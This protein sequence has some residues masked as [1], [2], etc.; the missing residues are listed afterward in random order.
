VTL[1]NGKDGTGKSCVAAWLRQRAAERGVSVVSARLQNASG[2]RAPQSLWRKIFFQLTANADAHSHDDQWSYANA[3]IHQAFPNMALLTEHVSLTTLSEALGV[4]IMGSGRSASDGQPRR[5]L[6]MV[7]KPATEQDPKHLRDAIIKI[8]VH[9]LDQQPTL[10]IIENVHL[11]AE[12]CLDL[13]VNLLPK[14]SH[15][16]AIVLTA[17]AASGQTM[18]TKGSKESA[19][20]VSLTAVRVST[21]ESAPWFMTYSPIVAKRKVLSTLVLSSVSPDDLSAM[22][23]TALGGKPVPPELLQLVQDFS[24]GSYFW[25]REILQ[26]IKEHG[27][28]QFL[29]AV[30]EG[31]PHDAD[32]D[33][34]P[35]LLPSPLKRGASINRSGL[36]PRQRSDTGPLT[37]QRSETGLLARAASFQS[38]SSQRA[39]TDPH[40]SKL[41]K[42]L[43]VRFGGLP[44]DAQRVL[45][46]ASV[47]GVTFTRDVL[48]EVLPRHL[49]DAL[50]SHLSLLVQ[51]MW[52]YED[53]DDDQLYAFSHPHAQQVIYKLT[54]S[55][56]RNYLYAKI[57]ECVEEKHG[58]DP[59]YF[60]AL[61]HYF[62]HCD[63]DKALQYVVKAEAALLMDVTTVFEFAEAVELL[64]TSMAL[65]KTVPDIKVM[66]H[67]LSN[68]RRS[69]E[70][71]TG[72][73]IKD[74]PRG[75]LWYFALCLSRPNKVNPNARCPPRSSARGRRTSIYWMNSSKSSEDSQHSMICESESSLRSG[76][77]AFTVSRSQLMLMVRKC[78]KLSGL[79]DG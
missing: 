43:L 77:G 30:G 7:P 71:Y 16:S 26:F 63:S 25:V 50:Q 31:T 28:D 78:W 2:S 22:L 5:R 13:L 39:V 15:P 54:P 42:L 62:R 38:A 36:L 76:T 41:D 45:R 24:G 68:C 73:H 33:G 18:P 21:V 51:Q 19:D 48:H 60:T 61:S 65:C 70:Q 12:H 72:P 20:S 17:L 34:R 69:I 29:S 35:G 75:G 32:H 4:G 8:F 40:H 47:I 57:A 58:T 49:K 9:L 27:A 37:R 67:L 56:E 6:S 14:L 44:V 64:S 10:I 74:A 79:K 59:A 53:P 46:T 23:R 1:I 52:L 55:S 3:I 11:A 66:S